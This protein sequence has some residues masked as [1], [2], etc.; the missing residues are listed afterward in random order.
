MLKKR[1]LIK[2]NE[3]KASKRLGTSAEAMTKAERNFKPYTFM[4]WLKQYL[5]MREGRTN[6]AAAT[7]EGD[8]EE[9]HSDTDDV[10]AN[11]INSKTSQGFSD[12]ES[13]ACDNSEMEN[14]YKPVTNCQRRIKKLRRKLLM[15]LS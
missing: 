2:Q 3:L 14:S 13:V 15:M 9:Y 12:V 1:Y 11:P 8:T 4:I 7:R 6:I 5:Q 10:I